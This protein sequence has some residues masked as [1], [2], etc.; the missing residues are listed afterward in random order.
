MCNLAIIIPAH[1]SR[2][3]KESLESLARQTDP[4]F[5]VYVGDDASSEALESIISA[6]AGRLDVHYTRFGANLGGSNLVHHWHRCIALS[7]GEPWLWLFSDDDVL[8]PGCVAAFYRSLNQPDQVPVDLYRFQLDQIDDHSNRTSRWAE[9]PA[10]ESTDAFLRALL[11]DRRRAFRAQE[12]IFS[13]EV[14]ERS[15]GFVAFPKAIYSDHA[16]WLRFSSPRGVRTIPGP[17]VMWRNHAAGTTSGLRGYHRD[18]WLQSARLYM[19]WLH[20]F[21]REQGPVTHR[22]FRE[23]GVAFY[24]NELARLRPRLSRVECQAAVNFVRD[25]F[26]VSA[27]GSYF[28]LYSALVRHRLG[29]RLRGSRGK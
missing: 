3:L 17:R 4:R 6:F 5:H 21:S 27:W 25:L 12:H 18:A 9:H 20:A 22:L 1:R 11:T 10:Y 16:T 13:R 29:D 7:E 15:G 2:H 26:R 8:D 24:F 19:G 28:R 14:Y 23:Q